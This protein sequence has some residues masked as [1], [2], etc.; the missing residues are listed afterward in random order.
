MITYW[1]ARRWT[2]SPPSPNY[3]TFQIVLYPNGKIVT[4]YNEAESSGTTVGS[5]SI[6]SDAVIGIEDSAGALGIGYRVDGVGGPMFGSP[7]ALAM[8]PIGVPLAVDLASFAAEAQAN[9]VLVT[10]ETVSELNNAGFNLYRSSSADGADRA[11]LAFVPSQSPGSTAGASY[12]VTDAAVTAGQ[13]YWYLLEDVDLNGAT[14]LH[15]PVSATVSVPT[16]VTLSSVS[17]GAAAGPALSWL[18]VAVSAGMALGL[19]RLRRRT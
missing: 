15:G 7:M 6:Q 14:T 1:H 13:A 17:A 11:L 2:A 8:A 18:W 19:S 9:Q 5:P 10:W 3:V 12:S 4:Q 16:A